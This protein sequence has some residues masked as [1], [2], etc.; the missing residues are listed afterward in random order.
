[1]GMN[2]QATN[3]PKHGRAGG[4]IHIPILTIMYPLIYT[5]L[6][7]LLSASLPAQAYSF[8]RSTEVYTEF[9]GGLQLIDTVDWDM[10]DFAVPLGFTFRLFG[11]P[12]D[13]LYTE[14][15]G[16]S[17]L[18]NV[19]YDTLD[20]YRTPRHVLVLDNKVDLTDRGL[21]DNTSLSSITYRVTGTAPNRIGIIQ[22]KN[23]GYSGDIQDDNVSDY[24]TN[25]QLWL[26]EKDG[27]LETHYGPGSQELKPG[28]DIELLTSVILVQ[29]YFY[30][31][32][33]DTTGFEDWYYLSGSPADP[34]F[35]RLEGNELTDDHYSLEGIPNSGTVYRFTASGTTGLFS[36]DLTT[37]SLSVFPNPTTD[38]INLSLPKELRGRV[39]RL[40]IFDGMGHRVRDLASVPTF[41]GLG[42]LPVGLYHLRMT[43]DAGS[44]LVGRV[45]KR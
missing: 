9:E 38:R 45:V 19:K 17:A 44:T 15:F 16:A 43:T 39:T 21:L 27:T 8:S 34:N 42:D 26:Y 4:L 23:A 20:D 14:D 5:L 13:T 22:W 6:L 31:E 35:K 7:I 28:D 29:H 18:G 24:F 12:V 3:P 40:E 30:D 36:P 10:A 25:F 33:S 41:V 11:T 37:V 1:M 2:V 32:E